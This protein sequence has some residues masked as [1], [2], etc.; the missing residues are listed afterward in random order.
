MKDYPYRFRPEEHHYVLEKI[1]QAR[2]EDIEDWN[3]LPQRFLMGRKV[4]KVPSSSG[5]VSTGD[6]LGDISIQPDYIYILIDDS[7]SLEWRR[8]ALGVF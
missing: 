8:A 5:D 2:K 4:G 6:K 3:N 7:G 1:S